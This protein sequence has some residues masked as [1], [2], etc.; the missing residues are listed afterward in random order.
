MLVKDCRDD[1]HVLAGDRGDWADEWSTIE[2]RPCGSRS[3]S[4]VQPKSSAASLIGMSRAYETGCIFRQPILTK[5]VTR[6]FNAV[7]P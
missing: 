6:S 7:A 4:N 3:V 1:V 2:R 5:G